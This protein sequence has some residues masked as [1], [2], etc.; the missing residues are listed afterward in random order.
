MGVLDWL[1]QLFNRVF[2]SHPVPEGLTNNMSVPLPPGRTPEQ[3]VDFVLTANERGQEHAALVAALSAEFSLSDDHAELA[4]DRVG[5]GM[6]RA[7][8][9]SPSNCPDGAKDPI[10][11]ASFQRA[12]RRA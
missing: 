1:Q 2:V 7:M 11:W 3:V 8:T 10:A 4:V 9:G 6:V 5:G 12:V